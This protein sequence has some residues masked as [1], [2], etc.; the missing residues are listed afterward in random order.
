MLTSRVSLLQ[1]RPRLQPAPPLRRPLAPPPRRLCATPGPEPDPEQHFD[2][3]VFDSDQPLLSA[4]PAEGCDEGGVHSEAEAAELEPP[5]EK[6]EM[7][8]VR[9]VD[10][11]VAK[12]LKLGERRKVENFL[13]RAK[14]CGGFRWEFETAEAAWNWLKKTAR[15]RLEK[16]TCRPHCKA[17]RAEAQGRGGAHRVRNHARVCGRGAEGGGGRRTRR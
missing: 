14:G 16:A 3:T 11:L 12:G 17:H 15:E 6:R 7:L 2:E 8:D 4:E 9:T 1:A 13:L 10:F 5:L